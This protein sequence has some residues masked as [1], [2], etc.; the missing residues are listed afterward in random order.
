[1]T[2][3]PNDRRIEL[4][5]YFHKDW[6]INK[7]HGFRIRVEAR[8]ACNIDAEVFRHY[9]YPPDQ[10]TGAT[11]DHFTGVCSWPDMAELPITEPRDTD[12]PKA[13]RLSYFDIVVDTEALASETWLLVKAEVDE[14]VATINSGQVLVAAD[15]HWAGGA[16]PL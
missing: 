11:E 9:R 5:P 7:H 14:L 10:L 15:T 8:N 6:V 12:C 13:F 16:P 4:V 1:V 2:C 3:G